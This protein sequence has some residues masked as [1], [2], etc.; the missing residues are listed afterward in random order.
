MRSLLKPRYV[1]VPSS[2]LL[3]QHSMNLQPKV[4][5]E[6]VVINALETQEGGANER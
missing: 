2:D 4:Y 6:A 5:T 1:R 3:V